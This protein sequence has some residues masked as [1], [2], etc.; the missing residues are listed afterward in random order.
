MNHYYI[1]I[2]SYFC[3]GEIV[4]TA[5]D[6]LHSE[7]KRCKK[8]KLGKQTYVKKH[9]KYKHEGVRYPCDQCEFAA[10]TADSLRRH[11]EIKHEGMGYPC[12]QGQDVKMKS[13]Q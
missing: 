10:I 5:E 11:I 2:S 13:K 8:S 4:K 3:S 9:I 1:S 7:P 6:P 12:D